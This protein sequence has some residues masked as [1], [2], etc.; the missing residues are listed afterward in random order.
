MNVWFGKAR[1]ELND[2]YTEK[3]AADL[4]LENRLKSEEVT[5]CK[6]PN[7]T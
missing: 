1:V 6:S 5:I 3:L 4:G 2:T 7:P